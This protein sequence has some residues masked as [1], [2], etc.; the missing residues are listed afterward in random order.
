MC[1]ESRVVSTCGQHEWT[2]QIRLA[3]A[4]QQ[5]LLVNK[6]YESRCMLSVEHAGC[7]LLCS[8]SWILITHGLLQLTGQLFGY[9]PVYRQG[10]PANKITWQPPVNEAVY[11]DRMKACQGAYVLCPYQLTG[12]RIICSEYLGSMDA[13]CHQILNSCIL[14]PAKGV[15]Q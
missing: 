12:P 6:K 1:W 4:K 11:S 9:M 15:D 8:C 10:C 3:V 5:Q 14:L 7:T 2:K 13:R